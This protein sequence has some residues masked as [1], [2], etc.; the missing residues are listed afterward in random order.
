MK[1]AILLAFA[2]APV[3][4]AA[5]DTVA[6]RVNGT[7]I[8]EA[9]VREVVRGL[10]SGTVPPSSEEI[11][12]L[13]DQAVESLIE[14]ELL[15]QD[16]Q[17]RGLTVTDAEITAEIQRTRA[18][19][20]D[21]SQYDAALKQSGLSPEAL[22]TDTRKTLMVNRLLADVVWK[23]IHVTRDQAQHFYDGNKQAFVRRGQQ[24]TFDEAQPAIVR[25]LRD[26]EER[27]RQQAFVA[28]L[29]QPAKIERPTPRY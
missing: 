19:F 16:A 1:F 27:K 29:R 3:A 8:T 25:L 21:Q 13:N 20:R 26:V 23:D 24:L 5:D 18:R 15:Y 11:T 9:M 10:I 12:K 7:P 17:A 14:F 6:A 2:L 22:R 4:L 28:Q